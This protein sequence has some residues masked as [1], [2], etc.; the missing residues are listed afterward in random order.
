MDVSYFDVSRNLVL[1]RQHMSLGGIGTLGE[2][3][4]HSVLKQYLSRDLAY[5]EIKVGSFFADVMI[6][7]HIFEIQT[8]QFNTLRRKLDFFLTD[9]QVTVV[10]PVTW[11]NRINWV[12]PDTGEISTAGKSRKVG[13]TMHVFDELYKIRPFLSHP[14]FSLKLVLMDT[15]EYRMLDGWSHDKKHGATKCDKF[16][17]SL[18]AEYDIETPADYMMLLP[19]ELP[20]TFT[21]K[22]FAKCAHI[23]LNLAQTA[24]LLLSELSVVHRVDKKGHA[25]IYEM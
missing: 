18:V 23:S 11:H 24:L 6:D 15:E 21:A 19:S 7:Q 2:K 16:P 14:N 12:A 25:Y 3:T 22:E 8:R 9:H 1:E 20:D 13:N 4:V 10:Y 17:L 5:Q